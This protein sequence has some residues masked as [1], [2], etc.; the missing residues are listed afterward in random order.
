MRVKTLQIYWHNKDPVFT[1]DFHPHGGYLATGGADKD[2][3]VCV[4]HSPRGERHLFAMTTAFAR[5]STGG[6]RVGRD[7]CC[8]SCIAM[9][10]AWGV[11]SVIM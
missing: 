1:L 11:C 5:C 10:A 9:H 3:K 7:G 2:I 4:I 8:L 6:V